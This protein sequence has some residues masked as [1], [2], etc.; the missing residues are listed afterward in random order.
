[1]NPGFD[2]MLRFVA[3]IWL[4]IGGLL[5][6]GTVRI[7]EKGPLLRAAWALVFCGGLGRAVSLLLIGSGDIAFPRAAL[8]ELLA[9]LLL[10]YWQ[11][12]VARAARTTRTTAPLPAA[13][14]GPEAAAIGV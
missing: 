10:T 1:M 14:T 8:V 2:S 6:W 4:G 3:G 5:A 13:G 9:P 11:H 7:E 12:R